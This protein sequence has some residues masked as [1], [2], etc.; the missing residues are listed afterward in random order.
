[1]LPY[2]CS[3]PEFNFFMQFIYNQR[4]DYAPMMTS[5]I[6]KCIIY[7]NLIIASFN[8]IIYYRSARV[9]LLLKNTIKNY[10]GSELGEKISFATFLAPQEKLFSH[11]QSV[12]RICDSLLSETFVGR[13][14]CGCQ[15]P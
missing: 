14:F 15:K 7:Y 10:P 6:A 3:K 12:F 2:L 1:M 13:K 11:L 8:Y 4:A 5:A 9:W